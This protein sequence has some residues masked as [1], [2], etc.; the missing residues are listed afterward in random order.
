MKK[1]YYKVVDDFDYALFITEVDADIYAE[2]R[3][4]K[5]HLKVSIYSINPE[6]AH[7]D[8]VT[9]KAIR[10]YVNGEEV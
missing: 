5:Y 9:G 7:S 2:R 10:T 4:R 6:D 1:Y 3:S 8:K